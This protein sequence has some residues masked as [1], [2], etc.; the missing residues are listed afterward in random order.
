MSGGGYTVINYF[1]A[2]DIKERLRDIVELLR[3]HHIDMDLLLCVRSTKSQSQGTIARIHGLGRIWQHAMKCKPTY[4]VEV[5]SERFDELNREQQ[6]WTLIH[7]LLHI[8]RNFGGGFLHHKNHVN[9][10]NVEIWYRRYRQK[11]E[12]LEECS[13]TR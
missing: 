11:L 2:P 9:K 12:E 1:D 13:Q 10:E 6:N 3:F 4:I 8:P 5:L 7:E